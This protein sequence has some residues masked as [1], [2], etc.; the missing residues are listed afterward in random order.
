MYFMF[1]F[2]YLYFLLFF[3]FFIFF[4]FNYIVNQVLHA[5]T[6]TK[7]IYILLIPV[8]VERGH[9]RICGGE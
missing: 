2:M 1:T 6:Y 8:I 4:T 5:H 3:Y 7:N 9:L